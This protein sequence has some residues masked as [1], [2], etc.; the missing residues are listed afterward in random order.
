MTTFRLKC[1]DRFRS[2]SAT[3]LRSS[4][5]LLRRCL[6]C[7]QTQLAFLDVGLKRFEYLYSLSHKFRDI[8]GLGF[9]GFKPN[10]GLTLR[11]PHL[12]I[13][14]I[15]DSAFMDQL[16]ECIF[17]TL[18]FPE[19]STAFALWITKL[20][21]I[22]RWSCRDGHFRITTLASHACF[23]ENHAIGTS[24]IK[25]WHR[26]RFGTEQCTDWTSETLNG[27]RR[28]KERLTCA[29]RHRQSSSGRLGERTRTR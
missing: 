29:R 27:S 5:R 15:P 24:D 4:L 26:T 11:K 23:L 20:F 21:G 17:N 8:L 22:W 3:F 12:A 14:T 2:S 7:L 16:P 25:V 6:Q 9:S 13:P 19:L 28:A 1:S 10:R 18:R